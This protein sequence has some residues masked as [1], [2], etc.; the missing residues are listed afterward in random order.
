MPFVSVREDF[1]YQHST[2]RPARTKLLNVDT[3]KSSPGSSKKT[4]MAHDELLTFVAPSNPHF[5][6]ATEKG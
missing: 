5:K 1:L 2:T 3:K 4:A 6:V